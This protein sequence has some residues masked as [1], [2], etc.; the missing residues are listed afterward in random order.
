MAVPRSRVSNARKNSRR[1]HHALKAKSLKKCPD[2][3]QLAMP[4]RAC[5]S[6]GTYK[7]MSV[8]KQEPSAQ[9]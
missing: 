3:G 4:H 5:L 6:C 9:A 8:R 1:A 7:G 2:C